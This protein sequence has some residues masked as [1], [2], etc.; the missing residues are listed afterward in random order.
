MRPPGAIPRHVRLSDLYRLPRLDAGSALNVW[1]RNRLGYAHSWKKNIL[2]NFFEP[3]LYLVALGYG[4]G[5]F[6]DAFD[7]TD[8]ATFIAPGL[9]AAAAM[10]GAVYEGTFNVFVKL[11]FEKIYETMAVTPARPEDLA[12]GEVLWG[13]TRAV[14]YGIPFLAVAGAL[15]H[16]DSWWV[17]AAPAVI[18]IIGLCFSVLAITFSVLVSDINYLNFFFSFFVTP[19]FLFSG[20][21]FPVTTLGE[22]ARVIAW[23]SPL[24]HATGALRQLL[25]VSP[26]DAGALITHVL[27]LSAVTAVL[28]PIAPNVFR[29]RLVV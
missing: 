26:L 21:F 5:R 11:H 2:P 8:Y 23:V 27:W 17:L 25:G 28:L 29:H 4:L 16:V 9:V 12:L 22:S 20:I 3:V 1:R 15:G 6:V 19:A 13:A 14:S 10:H 18:L 7:G 24:Y